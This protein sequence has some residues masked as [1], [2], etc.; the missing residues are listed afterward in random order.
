MNLTDITLNERR[1]SL[2]TEHTLYESIYVKFKQQEKQETAVKLWFTLS[3]GT[4]LRR[5]RGCLL[6]C[7]KCYLIFILL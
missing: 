2:K 1:Q 6:R 7:R 4:D 5:E 3:G